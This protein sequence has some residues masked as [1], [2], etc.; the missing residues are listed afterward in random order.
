M[1]ELFVYYR[2]AADRAEAARAAVSAMQTALRQRH[3]GL[4]A[5]LLRRPEEADGQQ[6]WM[7][8]YALNPEG[9]AQAI[10]DDIAAA[11]ATVSSFIEGPRHAEVF[12]P[13]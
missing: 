12:G 11:A 4:Q 5:R 8:T 3:P 10:Q 2:V 9:V 1:R 7:E 6:T 13:L